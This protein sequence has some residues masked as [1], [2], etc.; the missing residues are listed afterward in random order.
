MVFRREF[1]QDNL[2]MSM[3]LRHHNSFTNDIII[4]DGFWGGGKSVVTSLVGSLS[5][6]EKKKV[7]HVYEY[8]SI[9]HA[10]GKMK[11]DAAAVFLQI[12]ADL[13]QYNNLIGRE[14]NLRWADDSGFRNNPGSTKYL[15]RL[16]SRDGDLIPIKINA[17]NIA[18]LIASHKLLTTSEILYDAF[19]SRLKLIEVVRHPVHLFYNTRDYLSVFDRPREFD[20]A[21]DLNGVKIPVFA[22]NW[23]TEFADA[24]IADRALLTIARVKKATVESID[25]ITLSGKPILVLSFENTVLDPQTALLQLESFLGRTRTKFTKRV[26]RHQA[27]PRTQISAGKST[28]SFSFNSKSSMTERQIYEQITESI[29]KN[30]SPYA[31]KEFQDAISLYNSRWPSPL[32]ELESSWSK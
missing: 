1:R 20:L 3:D 19:G 30:A 28:S 24:S 18:L 4:V 31:I 16:F 8:V 26:L 14:V 23:A 5:R 9:T 29:T 12:Y 22:K 10:A 13:S 21:W 11:A 27:L 7:E 15:R 25:Q 17:E 2:T 6:V 32:A